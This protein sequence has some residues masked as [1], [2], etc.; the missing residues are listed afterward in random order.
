MILRLFSD[1]GT[2]VLGMR[3]LQQTC[4]CKGLLEPWLLQAARQECTVEVHEQHGVKLLQ[5]VSSDSKDLR[6]LL[7]PGFST[8]PRIG[9]FFWVCDTEHL[10]AADLAE[11]TLKAWISITP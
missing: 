7:K 9:S 11:T 6:A 2:T 10:V 8:L 5:T 1:S 4:S 3:P